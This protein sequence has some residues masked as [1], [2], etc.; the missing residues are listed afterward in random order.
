MIAWFADNVGS[1][2]QFTDTIHDKIAEITRRRELS[3]PRRMRRHRPENDR[4][5]R[6]RRD[7]RQRAQAERAAREEIEE[8]SEGED[9]DDE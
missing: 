7:A 6:L 1:E 3:T 2:M 8:D 4:F 5:W 9:S